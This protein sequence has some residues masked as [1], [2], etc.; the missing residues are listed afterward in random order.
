VNRYSLRDL[1]WRL[2]NGLART[3]RRLAF[4]KAMLACSR[5]LWTAAGRRFV[6]L[7][8]L[9]E[10]YLLTRINDNPLVGQEM[11]SQLLNVLKHCDTITYNEPG[12][13]DAYALLHFLDR[14]HRFQLTY[15]HL[16]L[17][18]LMPAKMTGIDVLDVGTGPGPSM[19]AASDFYN[20]RFGQADAPRADDRRPDFKIDYV[21]RSV[22]FR[23]WLHHFTEFAN[24][25]APTGKR[26][27][28]PYHHGAF[29]D[30]SNIEF[31]Q[32]LVSW[33]LDD[34]G[35]G[36]LVRS[37]QK[38]R[39]DLITFSNFLTTRDQVMHF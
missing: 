1:R 35:G 34:D 26:W 9:V 38:Y 36:K 18:G 17:R 27:Y 8:L 24:F 21:E 23:S 32:Q 15:A 33:E 7:S 3:I 10:K 20:E 25:F 16:D 29:H 19:F 12:T 28:V 37:I 22:E 4:E 31:E 14:Y 2:E 30:F 11:A 13:A 39:Y 6:E 5:K